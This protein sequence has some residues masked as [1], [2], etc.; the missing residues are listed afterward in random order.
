LTKARTRKEKISSKASQEDQMCSLKYINQAQKKER[1]KFI[2][3]ASQQDEISSNQIY[4]SSSSTLDCCVA[5]FGFGDS[6][7]NT[8]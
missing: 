2:P 6:L 5:I 4:H 3:G 7:T 8:N 1:K